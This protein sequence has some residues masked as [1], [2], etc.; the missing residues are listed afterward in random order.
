VRLVDRDGMDPGDPPL[1]AIIGG[2]LRA[3]FDNIGV[4]VL[5][6]SNSIQGQILRDAHISIRF[7]VYEDLHSQTGVSVAAEL[8]KNTSFFDDVKNLFT[9]SLDLA[10][11]APGKE[12]VAMFAKT[13][14]ILTEEYKVAV[15]AFKHIASNKVAWKD[16]ILSTKSGASKFLPDINYNKIT[17]EAWKKGLNVTNGKPWKVF[18]SND[19]IGASAGRET[20]YMRVELTKSTNELHSSPI[21]KQ[22]YEKL[23]K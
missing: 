19:I 13:P 9:S 16:I 21:T 5:K 14:S 12:G 22:Q 8:A 7:G 18:R 3:A 20:N 17:L 1:G 11:L 2:T 15:Y 23:L 6:Y 4:F 10:P